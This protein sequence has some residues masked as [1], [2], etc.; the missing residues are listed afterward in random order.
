MHKGAG[1]QVPDWNVSTGTPAGAGLAIASGACSR[2]VWCSEVARPVAETYDLPS[3]AAWTP[4]HRL[5]RI[6]GVSLITLRS[7]MGVPGCRRRMC[8]AASSSGGNVVANAAHIA[9]RC[10]APG[11]TSPD[12]SARMAASAVVSC[13]RARAGPTSVPGAR[14]WGR[15]QVAEDDGQS[16]RAPEREGRWTMRRPAAAMKSMVEA[17]TAR[18]RAGPMAARSATATVC[19][20][21]LGRLECSRLGH[22]E[23][24]AARGPGHVGDG[25]QGQE[26]QR[27]RPH[28]R[29]IPDRIRRD[30]RHDQGEGRP[31]VRPFLQ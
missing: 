24:A 22:R 7:T 4:D 6:T 25:Q 5:A 19:R 9:R 29:A 14:P 10:T 15:G 26:S 11:K 18:D 28:L 27:H 23:H 17:R 1:P 13:P 2:S 21:V 30:E 8:R 3:R 20:P 12:T 16:K 31:R